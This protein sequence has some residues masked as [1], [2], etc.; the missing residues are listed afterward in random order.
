MNDELF[1]EFTDTEWPMTYTDH[2]RMIVR[3]AV[4]DEEGYFYFVR[5]TRND[6]FGEATLIETS[7]GGVEAGEDLLA[8]IRRELKEELGADVDVLTKIGVVS[9]YY[10]LIHRHNVNNYYLCRVRS[11]GEKHLTEDEIDSFHLSTLKLRYEDAVREYETRTDSRLGRLIAQRELPVLHRAKELLDGFRSGSETGM[12]AK[13][14]GFF[15]GFLTHHFTDEIAETLRENLTAREKL[16]FISAWPNEFTQ[17]DDDGDGMHKMFEE[18]GMGFAAH[19]VIDRRTDAAD[20]AVLV[21]EADCIFLM[22]GDPVQQMQLIRDLGLVSLL[23]ESGAVILGVSAGSMNMG[24]YVAEIWESKAFYEGIGLWDV[25]IKAHCTE[26]D[27]FVPVLK[28][29]SKEHPIIAMED[30]S[31]IFIKDGSKR[32]I[33]R[34]YLIDKGVIT[35][36]KAQT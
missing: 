5:A 21:R 36:L 33:G 16:V 31:A 1:W 17:N 11:F 32:S 6:E 24:E 34:T 14:L 20:A 3:A 35:A 9:D 18:R 29:L 30:E 2:D 22:G 7:G 10:N 23:R 28:K 26:G 12:N 25:T 19:R 13:L 8:A 4:F 15:S 27:R